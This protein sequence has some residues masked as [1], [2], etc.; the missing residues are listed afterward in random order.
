MPSKNPDE[1]TFWGNLQRRILGSPRNINEPSIFRKISLIPVLAWIGLG[2]DGLSSSSYGPEEA[3][4]ALGPHTYLA[5]FLA[6]ATALTVIIISYAY[7]RIIE[8][9]P[10]GGG[11]YVVSTH[12]IGKSA[13]LV[14]GSALLVDYVLTITVSL[15][16]CGDALFSYL[17]SHLLKYKVL[18]VSVLICLLV[19]LNLRGV[20]ESVKILA[21]IFIVFVVTHVLLIGYGLTTH[22]AQIGPMTARF[23]ADMGQDMAVIGFAGILAIFLRAFSM[24]GG[25][26]TGI[27]AVSNAMHIM[28]EPKV[29]TGKRTMVYL[30]ASL[31]VTAGGL[32]LCYALFDIRPEHGRTINAVLADLAFNNWPLGGWIAFITILSEGALLMVGAQSGFAGGPSVMA[33]MAIDSWLPRRFAALSERLTMQNGVLLMGG[34]SLALLFYT[35]GS[36]SALVVMYSINVFLTFSLSQLG[37][38][39]FYLRRRDQ[40]LK[41]KRHILIHV[42]GLFLCVTILIVTVFEKFMEGGWV[43]LLITAGVITMCC[44]IHSHY[45]KVRG[46]VKMLEELLSRI[47]KGDRFND[48]PP[49]RKDMTAILLVSGYSGFGLHAWL[50]I[51]REFPEMY[52]NFVFVSVAEIDSGSFKGIAEVEAL[53]KNIRESLEKYVHLARSFGFPAEYRMDLGTDVVDTAVSLCTELAAQ[54]PRSTIF[55]GKLIF[56]HEYPFQKILHNETAFAIQRRLQWEGITTVILPIRVDLAAKKTGVLKPLT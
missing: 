56:R 8:H 24:G 23:Q 16:S 29:Q 39:S 1:L 31:S 12:T 48:A 28:R 11:G 32:L 35:G 20:K 21:P 3:F 30:A 43:T 40:H 50:T 26:Y 18:F 55:T 4:R 22:A 34:A 2:A 37:M 51:I 27:E 38:V 44:L 41:W 47:P 45:E 10:H 53:R 7:S 25:T 5:V 42:A 46:G 14:S 19:L 52:R 6:L 9:F 13:G 54:F 17:P 33:N 36:V 15:A 49:D